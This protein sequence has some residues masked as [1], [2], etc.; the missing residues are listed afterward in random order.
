[1]NNQ[2]WRHL[3]FGLIFVVLDILF[4]RH[5]SLFGLHIDPLLFYLLWLIP[6]YDRLQLILI[7]AILAFIQDA[8]YDYWGMMI[9]SKTLLIFLIYTPI[10]SRAEN[11]LLVWQIFIVVFVSALI[12]NIIFYAL[13]SFFNA[14]ATTYSPFFLIVGNAFYTSLIG[15]LIYI[16]RIR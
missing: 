14:Y 15:T 11:Q 3:V 9:F 6:K 10:K 13:G 7:T 2:M 4:F 1:M 12:H 16:F 5:L 8:V